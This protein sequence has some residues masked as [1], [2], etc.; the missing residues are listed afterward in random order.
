MQRL[1]ALYRSKTPTQDK[2]RS[3]RSTLQ[4]PAARRYKSWQILWFVQILR[5]KA[6]Q[7]LRAGSY[8]GSI[9]FTGYQIRN[10][11]AV[12][13]PIKVHQ[14]LF[15]TGA[16]TP[17]CEADRSECSAKNNGRSFMDNSTPQERHLDRTATINTNLGEGGGGTEAMES[18][19]V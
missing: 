13:S 16:E 3:E 11:E 19:A 2:A 15:A 10:L 1:L 17:D 9:P 8:L 7:W 5:H 4:L 6:A 14:R 12:Q 18:T